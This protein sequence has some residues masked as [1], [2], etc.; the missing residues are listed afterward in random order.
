MTELFK[1]SRDAAFSQ[2]DAL[3]S[4]EQRFYGA[5]RARPSHSAHPLPSSVR[6][7]EVRKR[8]TEERRRVNLR[9]AP[10]TTLRIFAAVFSAYVVDLVHWLL[11]HRKAC[12]QPFPIL[13]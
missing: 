4:D 10:V 8:R 11:Q 2:L 3:V 5:P 6:L 1:Y 9:S 13:R 12:R 7:D